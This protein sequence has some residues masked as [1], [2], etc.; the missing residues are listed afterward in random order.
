M[1]CSKIK[2]T[3]A[4]AL[5]DYFDLGGDDIIDG[6]WTHQ[7]ALDWLDAVGYEY[8]LYKTL[9]TDKN[10]DDIVELELIY[11]LKP[12]EMTLFLM[13]FPQVLSTYTNYERV[14]I[15]DANTSNKE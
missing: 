13:K 1:S 15:Y 8:K 9:K 2:F 5:D 3:V 6:L 7:T 10:N 12:E 11:S 4:M 14:R